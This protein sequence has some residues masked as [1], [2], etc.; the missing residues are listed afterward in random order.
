MLKSILITLFLFVT[1]QSI[2]N[3]RPDEI[4]LDVLEKYSNHRTFSCNVTVKNK[5]L[6][7]TDTNIRI[8]KCRLIKSPNGDFF[9]NNFSFENDKP[10]EILYDGDKIHHVDFF[11]SEMKYF[12]VDFKNY[13][14]KKDSIMLFYRRYIPDIHEFFLN[15]G[16]ILY[17]F[18][19]SSYSI[20]VETNDNYGIFKIKYPNTERIQNYLTE[21][22]VNLETSQIDRITTYLESRGSFQYEDWVY[23]SQSFDELPIDYVT[24]KRDSLINTF[25]ESKYECKSTQVFDLLQ[26][27]SLAPDF[28]FTDVKTGKEK[29]TSELS[30]KLFI[31]DFWYW[32]C[33]PCHSAIP[34]LNDLYD[35]YKNDSLI[36]LGLDFIDN[37]D[38]QKIVMHKYLQ[39]N[40]INYPV[41]FVDSSAIANYKVKAYP[42]IY[43]LDS[44]KRVIYSTVGYLETK[45][46]DTLDKIIKNYLKIEE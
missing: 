8:Y 11:D 29:H 41:V 35:K 27:G 33:A 13:R 2:S 38:Q 31:F 5:Y 46:T 9:K 25:G 21:I 22:Y 39:S 15:P 45:F 43:L 19:D 4:M 23:T 1:Y 16:S 3:I 34:R 32:S 14:N 30:G 18:T 26:T 42:T 6:F 28:S 37:N 40:Q 20:T 36:I 12:D 24:S 44:N 17:Y 7:K 10:F